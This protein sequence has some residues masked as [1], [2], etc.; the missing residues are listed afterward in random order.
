MQDAI[1]LRQLS[2]SQFAAVGLE[3]LAYIKKVQVEEGMFGFGV[4]SADG[5]QVAVVPSIEVAQALV[6]QHEMEPVLIH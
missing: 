4:F 1:D 2:S 5:R 3:Q 6:R